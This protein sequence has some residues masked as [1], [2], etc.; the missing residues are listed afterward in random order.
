MLLSKHY[1]FSIE[2]SFLKENATSF[3]LL[4]VW[5]DTVSVINDGEF[6][7]SFR[8]AEV[9]AELLRTTQQ[10]A[11]MG[12]VLRTED[13]LPNADPVVLISYD[14][15]Q[16]YF[17]GRGDVVGHSSRINGEL[18]TIIGVMPEGFGFPIWQD[19]WIP[20]LLPTI[21]N[22]DEE[23]DDLIV[24]GILHEGATIKH[25]RNEI[26]ALYSQLQNNWPQDYADNVTSVAVPYVSLRLGDQGAKTGYI[27]FILA[28]SIILLV[29]FNVSNLFVAR[30]EERIQELSIRSALGATPVKVA[31]ALLLESFIICIFG[32][33]LGLVLGLFTTAFMDNMLLNA[34]PQL[35][36]VFWWDMSFNSNFLP[37]IVGSALFIWILSGGLP[38]WR[39][40]RADLNSLI[41]NSGK[42]VSNIESSRLS[43]ILVNIQLI[44][45]CILMSIALTMVVAVSNAEPTALYDNTNLFSARVVVN[46]QLADDASQQSTYRDEFQQSLLSQAGIND[47]SYSSSL[48]NNGGPQV[49]YH[50]ED[51]DI[52]VNERY[53]EQ[54][55][56]AVSNNY[57]SFLET[58]LLQGRAFT[59]ED[60]IDSLPVAIIDQRMA[61]AYWPGQSALG[62]RVQL[63]PEEGGQWLTIIGVTEVIFQE[64]MLAPDETGISVIYQPI[65]QTLQ[66]QFSVIV[67]SNQVDFDYRQAIRAAASATNRNQA[68]DLMQ[69]LQELEQRKIELQNF[70]QKFM[71]SLAIVAMYLTAAATYGLAARAASRRR[72]EAGIRMAVG[73]SYF[74]S[75]LAFLKAGFQTLLIGLSI[76]GILGILI[77]YQLLN[78]LFSTMNSFAV[79]VP[80]VLFICFLMGCTVMLANYFP[81]RKII[82]MEPGD[83]LR[84]E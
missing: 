83:A 56:L 37:T 3:R 4:D 46:S 32:V 58:S 76:G 25:A 43:K 57:F 73:A 31:Q 33:A 40:S 36:A 6:S 16:N 8:S 26:T 30:G 14:V 68:V 64:S 61:D 27:F 51:Q 42:G 54:Y 21:A 53:P 5:K 10:Q 62:K 18:R 13:S 19:L 82:A 84:Y 20:V 79:L 72:I 41:S 50:L 78:I 74:G 52:K 45:G 59:V 22:L 81:A 9:S 38:A 70:Q 44:F 35:G 67:K 77:G 29:A 39:I 47:L 17:A 71:L 34:N 48:P 12:R 80:V 55:H 75:L 60:A 1:Y 7:E 49:A 63:K 2:Y 11:L 65:Q 28:A 23:P 66:S 69:S 15:W 24:V